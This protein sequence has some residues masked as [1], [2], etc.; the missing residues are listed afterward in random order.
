MQTNTAS[1]TAKLCAYS[2]WI[3]SGRLGLFN[4]YLAGELLGEQ[5]QQAMHSLINEH[6]GE[7]LNSALPSILL[8]RSAWAEGHLECFSQGLG[9][10]QYVILGAGLDTFAFRNTNSKIRIFEVDHPNTQQE[11]L[12]RIAK[13]NWKL[14][15]KLVFTSVD[16]TKDSL[17]QR[18]LES[19][20]NPFIPTFIT[21]LG[22]A[23]Y[24]P[25]EHF[26][27]TVSELS[28]LI[29]APSRL[30]FDFQIEGFQNMKLPL[31]L[32]AFTKSLG[33]SMADGY[34]IST[35]EALLFENG[36]QFSEHLTPSSI[37]ERYFQ[38]NDNDLKAFDS[39]HFMA[40]A[41]TNTLFHL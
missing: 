20:F 29:K 32:A 17:S 26:A 19:G 33:E 23:Y 25:F 1:V 13:L 35:L 9:D 38:Q 3:N 5:E 11:K 4:D 15:S 8:S 31:E 7:L 6:A 18:L 30:L 16:F 27:A 24:L 40:A 37:N 22:V 34:E 10:I 41:F 39:V 2:R 36:W 21:I 12:E 28:K 14:N